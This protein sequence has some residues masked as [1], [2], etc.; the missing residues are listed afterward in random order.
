VADRAPGRGRGGDAVL[1]GVRPP[2]LGRVR[3]IGCAFPPRGVAARGPRPDPPLRPTR[4]CL[5]ILALALSQLAW[6]HLKAADHAPP[7]PP[8]RPIAQLPVIGVEL[9]QLDELGKLK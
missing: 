2:E 6:A 3:T 4:P 9:A 7:L 8:S 1:R 5:G